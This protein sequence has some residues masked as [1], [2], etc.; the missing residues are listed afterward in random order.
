MPRPRSDI[1]HKKVLEAALNLMAERGLDATSMDA[2][3]GR[4]GVS[5]ATIYNHWADKEALLL[6][7]MAA[8]HGLRDRPAFDSGN[9]R[10]DMIAV[11]AYQP[12]KKRAALQERI[13]PH[14]V[15]YSARNP[16]FGDAWRS[17]ALGPPRE[18]LTRLVAQAL[19]SGEL[20]GVPPSDLALSLLLGPIVYN[21]IFGRSKA[22][23]PEDLARIVVDEFWQ[24]FQPKPRRA[25]PNG[26]SASSSRRPKRNRLKRSFAR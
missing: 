10:A 26:S 23:R 13:L 9:A 19:E 4:S 7:A 24:A 11:L 18:E 14:F 1:A 2:I 25:H 16:K 21:N 12:A 8:L 6:E 15:A 20:A 17:M 5:K 22:C 3:A